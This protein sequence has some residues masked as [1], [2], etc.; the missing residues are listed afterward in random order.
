MAAVDT[1]CVDAED[2][3]VRCSR[4]SRSSRP[5][6][7]AD[8]VDGVDLVDAVDPVNTVDPV[9]AIDHVVACGFQLRRGTA[10]KRQ[11]LRA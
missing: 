6:D 1:V 4:W 11:G 2:H 8:P 7:A 3:V 9:D 5:V 10:H